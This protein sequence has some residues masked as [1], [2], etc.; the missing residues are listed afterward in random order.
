MAK[1]LKSLLTG[2]NSSLTTLA[3]RASA[4]QSLQQSIVGALPDNIGAA[5]VA[6]SIS[7]DNALVVVAD[8]PNWAARL[9]FH[10]ADMLEAARRAGIP[11][12]ACQIKVRPQ[13]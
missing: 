9:R 8:D 11:A 12:T 6:A 13:A 5:I 3:N 2:G 10:S 1:D 4:M 7:P